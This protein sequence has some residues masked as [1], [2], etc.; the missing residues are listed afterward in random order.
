MKVTLYIRSKCTPHEI[1]K[2]RLNLIKAR[3]SVLVEI[4]GDKLYNIMEVKPDC[5]EMYME[6]REKEFMSLPICANSEF[7]GVL[8]E[9][10]D[11]LDSKVVL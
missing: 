1:K 8:F 4:V 9:G 6:L 5:N 10:A 2:H 3:D 11:E 7:I